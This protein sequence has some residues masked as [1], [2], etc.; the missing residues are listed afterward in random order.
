MRFKALIEAGFKANSPTERNVLVLSWLKRNGYPHCTINEQGEVDSPSALDLSL[1]GTMKKGFVSGERA[2]HL[3]QF[4]KIDGEFTASLL[5]LTTLEGWCP[6]TVTGGCDLSSNELTNL[7]GGPQVVGAR[8]NVSHNNLTSLEGSPKQVDAFV[9]A[10]N[11]LTTLE[12]VTPEIGMYLDISNNKFTSL[13]DIHKHLKKIDGFLV[14][15]GNDIKSHVL[16]LFLI[17]GLSGISFGKKAQP[18]GVIVNEYL[19]HAHSNDLS[20]EDR[21]DVMIDCQHELIEKGY[22]ELAQL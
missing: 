3:P 14:V 17:D 12:G 20:A 2:K 9:A 8:F 13:K 5:E 7:K 10:D 19:G 11:K 16:G 1:L 6:H 18:W 21:K 4:G 22:E 15:Q